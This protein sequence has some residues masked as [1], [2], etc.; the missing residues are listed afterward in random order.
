M[1]WICFWANPSQDLVFEISKIIQNYDQ[2]YISG[3]V[4]VC[5]W[6]HHLN[7]ISTHCAPPPIPILWNIGILHHKE[8]K[9]PKHLQHSVYSIVWSIFFLQYTSYMYIR[10]TC[11]IH[12]PSLWNMWPL[13]IHCQ[14][15]F[16]I[17]HHQSK[18]R[19]KP[20]SSVIKRRLMHQA[21]A[22][23]KET[24]VFVKEG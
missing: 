6:N 5:T 1:F 16:S 15:R 3:L 24:T 9:L 17:Q 13:L 8:A 12:F 22:F 19:T 14:I 10:H 4:L 2:K 18:G 20:Y 23:Q 21:D 11:F 7:F